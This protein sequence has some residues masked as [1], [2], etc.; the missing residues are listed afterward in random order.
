MTPTF[1]QKENRTMYHLPHRFALAAFAVLA[2]TTSRLAIADTY[3]V[4]DLGALPGKPNC[5]VWQQ[6]INN[7]GTIAAYANSSAD[8]NFFNNFI[9]DSPFLWQNGTITPL[10]ELPGAVDTIPFHLNNKGQMV[11]RSTPAL[12]FNHAVLWDHGVI[13][14]LPELPGD[15]RSA[16][17]SINERGQ[18]VG[19]SRVNGNRRAAL[20]ERGKVSQLPPLPGGGLFDEG[21][22]IN[23]RDQIVGWSGPASGLEHIA[24]W[25]RG[26]VHDLGTLGGDWGEAVALN[27]SGQ[28]VGGSATV[29]GNV[30]P[31][32]WENGVLTDLGDFDGDVYGFAVDINKKGRIVG[33]SA[34]DITDMTT[35]HALLWKN[36]VR[37]NL[38]TKIPA[39]SGWTL[40][41]AEGIND[42]GRIA[43][44]GL[45]NGF[46]RSCLLTPV[47]DDDDDGDGGDD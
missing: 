46:L 30:D 24:L 20:W 18:A 3:T 22:D 32:L 42:H 36:G 34:G 14:T 23:E 7:S 27:E 9:G 29:F 37:I 2:L 17:L 1:F 26:G 5:A 21:M 33:F 4:T 11:G 13:Q 44:L 19:Y 47:H 35:F 15:T 39:S 12:S 25:D 6:T 28:V 45:H 43:A 38:Q 31:F 40:L 10:P 8:D 41:Q 16:A